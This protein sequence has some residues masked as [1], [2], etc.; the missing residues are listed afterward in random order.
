MPVRNNEIRSID[1]DIQKSTEEEPLKLRG[2]AIVYNSLSEPLYGDLFRERINRGAFTKSL[3]ENDQVCLWG[4][5]TRY[6]LGR[7]SSGTLILREDEKGLYF[8]VSMPNTTWARDLKES[9]DRGDIKQMSF[10]FKVV[11]DN[12]I[13]DKE[14]L[15]EYGMP[16]REVEEIT[17][18]E[19]SLVTF[20]A[21]TETNVRHTHS[22][23]EDAYIPTPPQKSVI[24]DGFDDRS[25]EYEIKIKYLK[26]KNK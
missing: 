24:N 18:H 19:I 23:N 6:V 8:E 26:I 16:I 22:A 10:G 25:N 21:Y 1:I 15:K 9:V 4:H 14:T 5:D 7:K 20:P 3:L 2:Y 11:R 12:W 17:L 13:D